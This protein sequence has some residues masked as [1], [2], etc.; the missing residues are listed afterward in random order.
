MITIFA[1][2]KPFLGHIGTIQRNAIISWTLLEPR[3]EI[4]LFGK[5]EGVED[6][7]RELGLLHMPDIEY[8]RHGTPLLNFLFE[9]TEKIAKNDLLGYINPDVILMDDFMPAVAKTVEWNKS[10]LLTGER[11]D[12]DQEDVI[13]YSNPDWKERLRR[14]V[15]NEAESHGHGGVDYFIFPK[16]ALGEIPPFAVGRKYYDCWFFWK[17]SSQNIPVVDA[18]EIVTCIHQNHERTYTSI[19]RK[20]LR[21][22]DRLRESVEARENFKLTGGGYKNIYTSLC[23]THSLTVDGIITADTPKHLLKR[24][25][26]LETKERGAANYFRNYGQRIESFQ[27]QFEETEQRNAELAADIEEKDT[28]IL[29][30]LKESVRREKDLGSVME[31]LDIKS[32]IILQEIDRSFLRKFF[33][34]MRGRKAALLF[35]S[36]FTIAACSLMFLSW[37]LGGRTGLTAFLGVALFAFIALYIET[38]RRTTEEQNGRFGI[39]AGEIAENRV[40]LSH[41]LKGIEDEMSQGRNTTEESIKT[42]KEDLKQELDGTREK[43]LSVLTK[44]KEDLETVS[45]AQASLEYMNNVILDTQKKIM[46]T[47]EWHGETIQTVS[48]SQEDLNSAQSEMAQRHENAV[49]TQDEVSRK[50]ADTLEEL[51]ALEES[52]KLR[53]EEFARIQA[54]LKEEQERLVSGQARVVDGQQGIIDAQK[55]HEAAIREVKEAQDELANAQRELSG[56]HES[57][58]RLQDEISVKHAEAIAEVKALEETISR[59]Q[60]EFAR[61]QAELKGTQERL[62]SEQA[63]ALEGQREIV[64]VQREHTAAIEDVK[65]IEET[66]S[67]R[68]EEFARMQVELKEAQAKFAT[69]QQQDAGRH[70]AMMDAQKQQRDQLTQLYGI[71][72]ALRKAQEDIL[73]GLAAQTD[74]Q[75]EQKVK[76][77]ELAKAA[78]AIGSLQKTLSGLEGQL[79]AAQKEI[80]GVRKDS[81]GIKTDMGELR[82]KQQEIASKAAEAQ[83]QFVSAQEFL[84]KSQDDMLKETAA[85]TGFREK[86]QNAI[87]QL[88]NIVT[89]V[90]IRQEAL[91]RVQE[92]LSKGVGEHVESQKRQNARLEELAKVVKE[93]SVLQNSLEVLERQVREAK[94]NMI[95]SRNE[96]S[97]MVGEISKAGGAI[98]GLQ[99]TLSSLEE[100]FKAAQKEIGAARK[101][102][103]GV[104]SDI[105]VLRKDQQ[106]TAIRSEEFQ[107]QIVSA[108]ESLKKAQEDI[109]KGVLA[110]TDT[111]KQQSV[112]IDELSKAGAAIGTLQKT[113]GGLEG[114]LKAAQKELGD[115]SKDSAGV[116][117]DIGALSKDQQGMI[118]QSEAL[119]KQIKTLQKALEDQ[120]NETEKTQKELI[121]INAQHAQKLSQLTA[122]ESQIKVIGADSGASRNDIIAYRKELEELKKQ[123]KEKIDQLLAIQDK[124]RKAQEGISRGQDESSRLQQDILKSQKEISAAQGKQRDKLEELSSLQKEI[125]KIQEEFN[126][127]QLKAGE[128]KQELRSIKQTLK[129][130]DA[131]QLTEYREFE[132][133]L[134]LYATVKPTFPLPN[135]R[136]SAISPDFAKII[137]K[138]IKEKQ[139]KTI[140]ELGSGVSTIISG[141]ALN[142]NGKGKI[143]SLEED[144]TFAE[145]TKENIKRHDLA[146]IARVICAPLKDKTIN[147]KKWKWYDISKLKVKS[148]DMLVVDGPQQYGRKESMVRY[149]ALPVLFKRLSPKA[150]ILVDDAARED[151]KRIVKKWTKEYKL[152]CQYIKTE[153]GAAILRR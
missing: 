85:Q 38:Y 122:I 91:R 104:K 42:L 110:Q 30:K 119:Q 135:T 113:L 39:L 18:T 54:E 98:S 142:E 133:L 124:F 86:Q 24:I 78:G 6:I 36:S 7:C 95:V 60:E 84:K 2:P 94:T 69:D 11:W 43:V 21:G 62:G 32:D 45:K 35:F 9:K 150:I 55:Q 63:R 144:P 108:Q 26:E 29:E 46:A 70:K 141:Y 47:L 76:M 57:T 99:K 127:E 101:D 97:G 17:V 58:V 73:K 15:C 3:P 74:T 49:R 106:E 1:I 72:E 77:E 14:R 103:A 25:R 140:V 128:S 5:D 89:R 117:S 152:I 33:K 71:Q 102:S 115:V 31:Q 143:V 75:K 65:V 37:Y 93:I 52:L 56:R 130:Q 148:I 118:K 48:R 81:A 134:A 153:K 107:K 20:P 100:Q 126:R 90:H 28:A 138:L 66:I 116:K 109:M 79:K 125:R 112:K 4:I 139:P 50:H 27:K 136:K 16:G 64:D 83:D 61:M 8:N 137:V 34:T 96:S 51:K 147:K 120:G 105:G 44:Y 23:A 67:R 88:Q 111:Q 87:L 41:G 114:Q 151:E 19:G 68:Q 92:K 149:P 131:K 145:V 40:T 12:L 121:R 53:Q 123:Q 59:R 146:S 82:N 10:F 13:D 80:D 22:E 129:Q 132:S